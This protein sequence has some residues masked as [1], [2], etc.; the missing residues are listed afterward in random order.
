MR[1][2]TDVA[3]PSYIASIEATRNLVCTIKLR[4]NGDR[5]VRH[6]SAIE[7]FTTNQ[8]PNLDPEL[9]LTQRNLYNAA[10]TH[11]LDVLLASTSKS[12]GRVSS[13]L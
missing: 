10:S 1:H 4:P 11:R 2:L 9:R 7:T 5:P 6:V 12:T 3:L 8:W 13:P